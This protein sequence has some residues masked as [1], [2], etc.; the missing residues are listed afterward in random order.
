MKNILP[1]E[2][3]E[4]A[5]YSER[6]LIVYLMSKRGKPGLLLRNPGDKNTL[7]LESLLSLVQSG[8]VKISD[9]DDKVVYFNFTDKFEYGKI[10]IS[11]GSYIK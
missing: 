9:F 6:R 1:S 5:N 10:S 4:K 2:I 7:R 8:V 3:I 11:L